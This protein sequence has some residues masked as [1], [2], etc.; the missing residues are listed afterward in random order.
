MSYDNN[1]TF[2]QR[3][4]Y[5]NEICLGGVGIW[6]VDL[7]TYDWQAL[8]ALTGKDINGGSLLT[9]GEDPTTLAAAYNAYTGADCYVSE[10]VDWNTGSCK[11]GYSVLD[12]VHKGSMSVIE[13]PD[14]KL[15][16]KGDGAI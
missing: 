5:A 11:S 12:Y 4:D 16:S 1:V 6:A 13:D 8:S 15:C 3:V 14:K 9:S 10:C 2:K 7:D